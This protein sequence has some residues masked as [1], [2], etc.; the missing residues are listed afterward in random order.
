[1]KYVLL[2]LTL[3]LITSCKKEDNGTDPADK[4]CI[5]ASI[6]S[7][8]IA[9]YPF[10]NS[11]I[12][13]FK[14]DNDLINENNAE[15]TEGREGGVNCAYKF[16]D[17]SPNYLYMTSPNFLNGLR[18]YSIS[19]WYKHTVNNQGQYEVLVA[20]GDKDNQS[21]AANR[22]MSVGVY[23]INKVTFFNNMHSVWDNSD[24]N[25]LDEWY[26]VVATCDFDSKTMTLYQNGKL[27]DTQTSITQDVINP[28]NGGD[29][30]IGKYF[31]GS[32][33]DIAF[34]NKVLTQDE[35]IELYSIESCCE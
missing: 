15:P 28:V 8:L 16:S 10:S 33:D 9:Y 25:L 32:I 6:E 22:V 18:K 3:L 34:F 20:R 31:N 12:D 27:M 23:D 30:I 2:T 4:V 13:D 26:H 7:N 35:I 24:Q 14:S 5:P 17:A 1:M 21:P 19:L 29:L 11:S